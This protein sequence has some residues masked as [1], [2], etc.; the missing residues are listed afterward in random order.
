MECA[1][2]EHSS[3]LVE[4]W[5]ELETGALSTSPLFGVMKQHA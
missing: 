5:T 3:C 4:E 1:Y 2:Y